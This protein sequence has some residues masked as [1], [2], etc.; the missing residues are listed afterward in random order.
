MLN[1]GGTAKD[2][3]DLKRTDWN[4]SAGTITRMREKIELHE[5]APTVTY[6]L[7]PETTALLEKF[8]QSRDRRL[9]NQD[10][11]PLVVER[12]GAD[13]KT[14][15]TDSVATLFRRVA[16]AAGV[17]APPK[18]CRKTGYL[19]LENDGCYARLVDQYL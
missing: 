7:W 1:V 13:E 4:R 15:R 16:T 9:V 11:N 6:R 18:S 8:A 5:S 19:L 3:S 2:L 10:G 17:Q 12:L 14:K